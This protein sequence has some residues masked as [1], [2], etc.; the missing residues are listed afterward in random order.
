MLCLYDTFL[1]ALLHAG[2]TAYAFLRVNDRME[3]LYFHSIMLT[4]LHTDTAA[5]T[6]CCAG[7]HGNGTFVCG[8]TCHL[9]GIGIWS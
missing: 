9:H 6:A 3:V 8:T 4:V 1:R 5:H 2:T 7:F